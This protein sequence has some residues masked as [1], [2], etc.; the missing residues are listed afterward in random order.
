MNTS[1]M[2]EALRVL[3]RPAS[4]GYRVA[5]AMRNRKF[6][7]GKNVT[8][9]SV[10]VISV[11]NISVGG[12]GKT[13]MVM[14]MCEWLQARDMH[15]CI[16]MRGYAA[17]EG[18]RSDEEAEYELRFPDIPVLA[19]PD[20]VAALNGFLPANPHI[21]CVIMDDGFQHR[22]LK[23]D[24]DLVLI[25]A[26]VP[27]SK[28]NLL[29][30]GYL[31]EP[32]TALRRATA[33]V[34]THAGAV[35][36]DLSAFVES[37]HGK[38]PIAWT[39]HHWPHLRVFEHKSADQP[40]PTTWLQKKRLVTVLGVGN[41]D[42]LLNHLKTLGAK[43]SVNVPARDHQKFDEQFAATLQR[44]CQGMDALLVTGKD[45]V[46]LQRLIDPVDF[47]VPI[48]IPHLTLKFVH[49]EQTLK[50]LLMGAIKPTV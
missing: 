40:V 41:P 19:Q 32:V 26:S 45:W 37:A 4:W 36:P 18:Q 50:D 12:V 34:I 38:P 14:W 11:G 48:V 25:D 35:D 30:L 42:H 15:P 16:V 20:R 5:V 7:Q 22:M 28:D 6:D 49:G 44:R 1:P 3:A 39:D 24:I 33:V 8:A 31:R 46:K 43:I 9:V 2:P 27:P 21:N 10:P 13:P 47:P 29:P 23:R 17:E